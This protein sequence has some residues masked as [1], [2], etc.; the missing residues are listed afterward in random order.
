LNLVVR[1]AVQQG[2][3]VVEATAYKRIV[4]VY[5]VHLDLLLMC[6]ISSAGSNLG[7]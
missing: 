2:I 5:Y 1:N 4:T 3:A 6:D 7:P